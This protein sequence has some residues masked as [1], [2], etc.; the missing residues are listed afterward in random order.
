MGHGRPTNLPSL[1]INLGRTKH[2]LLRSF[3]QVG[4]ALKYGKE[5]HHQHNATHPFAAGH[6]LAH[7]H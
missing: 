3:Q 5:H 4:V 7:S 6:S 2:A 1:D